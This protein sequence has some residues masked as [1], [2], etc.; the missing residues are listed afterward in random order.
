MTRIYELDY[1]RGIAMLMVVMGH[2][3]LFSLKIEHTALIGIIG[4]CEMPLFF[5]V[6]GYLTHKEREENFKRMLSRL[7]IRSRTLLVPL[8]VWS[9]VRNICDGTVSYSLS[10]I[11]RGGVLVLSRIV[12]VRCVEYVFGLSL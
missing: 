10:D 1:I 4:I 6:S 8:V 3:L 7:L 5:V 11:Y 12:V 2:V 9:I